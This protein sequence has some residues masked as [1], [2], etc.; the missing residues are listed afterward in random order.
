MKKIWGITKNVF[1]SSIVLA[2]IFHASMTILYNSPPNPIKTLTNIHSEYI[3]Q[4]FYQDWGLFAPTP[5]NMDIKLLLECL[6]HDGDSSGVLDVSGELIKQ[7]QQNRFTSYERLLRVPDNY[8]HTLVSQNRSEVISGKTCEKYPNGKSCKEVKKQRKEREEKA[9]QGL[10]RVASAFCA[11]MS[12]SRFGKPFQKAHAWVSL[13][14]VPKWSKRFIEKK[15]TKL[16]EG[17]ILEL[18]PTRAYGIWK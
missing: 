4:F 14:S 6:T 13:S 1:Y 7:H 18:T 9:T 12:K 17:G 10:T 3:G 8:A 2:S 16:V 5:I 11:D 15:D